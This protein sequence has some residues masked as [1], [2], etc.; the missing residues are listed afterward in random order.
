MGMV[1]MDQTEIFMTMTRERELKSFPLWV[2][3]KSYQL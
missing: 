3:I 1:R 2:K